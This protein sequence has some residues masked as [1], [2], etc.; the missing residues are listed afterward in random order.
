MKQI[1]NVVIIGRKWFDKINGNTYH[2]AQVI[3]N[4]GEM[5]IRSNRQYGYGDSYIT[6]A[7][8]LLIDND[9]SRDNMARDD[10]RNWLKCNAIVECFNV[11]KR[12]L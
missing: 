5:N 2:S 4:G 10:L 7:T 8:E 1:N 6:T 9:Y 12:D 3:I 11:N